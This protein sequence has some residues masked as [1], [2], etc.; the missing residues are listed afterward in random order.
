MN[1][2]KRVQRDGRDVTAAIAP[3]EDLGSFKRRVVDMLEAEAS[4]WGLPVEEA[5]RIFEGAAE[6]LRKKNSQMILAGRKMHPDPNKEPV[7]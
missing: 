5:I 6:R 1:R 4:A 3:R 2:R 7:T